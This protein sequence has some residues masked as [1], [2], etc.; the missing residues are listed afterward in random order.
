MYLTEEKWGHDIQSTA[1]PDFCELFFGKQKGSLL[2]GWSLS[3]EFILVYKWVDNEKSLLIPGLF[4]IS[5]FPISRFDCTTSGDCSATL[6]CFHTCVAQ[7]Q[8]RSCCY[9]QRCRKISEPIF[10]QECWSFQPYVIFWGHVF[11]HFIELKFW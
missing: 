3:R 7:I 2:W 8:S 5:T 1:K 11:Q 9:L 6:H 4:T 10:Q